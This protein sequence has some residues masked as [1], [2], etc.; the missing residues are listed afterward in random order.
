[1]NKIASTIIAVILIFPTAAAQDFIRHEF[2]FNTGGGVSGFQTRPTIGKDHWKGTATLGLGYHYSFHPNWGIGSGVNL[3]AYNGKITIK[4][5][6]QRQAAINTLTDNAFDFLV[7]SSNYEETQRAMMITI[8]LMVQYQHKYKYQFKE[9]MNLYAALGFK[10]GIPVSA[11]S[12]SKGNFSTKGYYPNL[13]V[14][15]ENLPDY[16]FVTNQPF[17]E[18]KTNLGL[19]TAVMASAE[20]GAKYPLGK[21]ISLYTGIYTDYGLNNMLNKKNAAN[22]LVIFQSNTPAQFAYNAAINSYA[23]KMK[24]FAVGITL[25][26]AFSNLPFN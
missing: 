22:N 14:T 25:R 6:D 23:R 19:K 2:S 4:D 1:M 12:K 24:P 10:A 15:Y 3:T 13:N 9:K 8:P 16:G 17:P 5:Y 7:S 21:N 11:K 26:F 18:N 20:L